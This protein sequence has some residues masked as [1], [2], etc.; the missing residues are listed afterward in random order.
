VTSAPY[1][2]Q[3]QHPMKLYKYME[4]RFAGRFGAVIGEAEE[5]RKYVRKEGYAVVDMAYPETV[6]YFLK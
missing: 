4:S 5:G 2:W 1:W 6:P 3:T